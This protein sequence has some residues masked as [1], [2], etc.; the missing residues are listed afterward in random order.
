[1]CRLSAVGRQGKDGGEVGG[2]SRARHQ[3]GGSSGPVT[4]ELEHNG[5]GVA[6][7]AAVMAVVRVSLLPMAQKDIGIRPKS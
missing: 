3:H 5:W 2:N 4:P 7:D 1:M 6:V